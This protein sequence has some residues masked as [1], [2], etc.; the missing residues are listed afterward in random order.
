MNRCILRQCYH[1]SRNASIWRCQCSIFNEPHTRSSPSELFSLVFGRRTND[2]KL[3]D[4]NRHHLNGLGVSWT[5]S[6][7]SDPVN[8]I[9]WNRFPGIAYYVA[10]PLG[11]SSAMIVNGHF[12]WKADRSILNGDRDSLYSLCCLFHGDFIFLQFRKSKN[13]WPCPLARSWP[14]SFRL[15]PFSS[16]SY[17]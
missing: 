10:V 2:E 12:H 15:E 13:C 17:D 16:K 7:E 11:G 5:Q 4:G 6:S 3:L 9:Q 14:G 1:W 8:L